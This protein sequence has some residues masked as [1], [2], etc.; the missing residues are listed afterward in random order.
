M[1]HLEP[2]IALRTCERALRDLYAAAYQS[3]YGEDWLAR[4][5]DAKAIAR[6][7]E[8]RDEEHKRRAGRGVASVPDEHLAYAEFYGLVKIASKDW[9]PLHAALGKRA[10]MLPLLERFERLRNTVAHNRETLP[11]EDDLL[12]GIA[13][14]IRNRVTRYM[15]KRDPGGDFF[16]RIESAV[17]SLGHEARP[18]RGDN[19]TFAAM[20]EATIRAGDHVRFTC[21]ATDPQGR[22]ISWWIHTD[23]MGRHHAADGPDVTLDWIAQGGDV[24]VNTAVNI[25][26]RVDSVFHRYGF[27]SHDG[28][29]QFR[30]TILPR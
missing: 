23:S 28:L 9:E 25:E 10:E 29:V 16:A 8:K 5:A 27:G 20:T 30:Y 24:G 18:L 15:S 4:I 22:D 13:G 19:G 11:F 21:R 17:D 2:T 14:E 26:M 12:A 7:E 3:A 6:W 1:G